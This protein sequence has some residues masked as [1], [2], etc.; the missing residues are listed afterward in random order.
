M[1]DE[2]HRFNPQFD[3]DNTIIVDADNVL[4]SIGQSIHWG[5]LLEGSNI[6]LNRNGTAAADGLTYQT[7]ERDIF[8]GGDAYT[9]PKFAIDA[10]AAG[11]QAAISMH[12]AVQPGQSLTIGQTE[13]YLMHLIR[14]I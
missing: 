12:R 6:K 7:D 10:I 13:G 2:N 14:K 3:E 4:L 9:G 1:F 5:N 8:A 11:K